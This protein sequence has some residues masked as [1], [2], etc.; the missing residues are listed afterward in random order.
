MDFFLLASFSSGR[1]SFN[2]GRNVA[3]KNDTELANDTV[4][5]EFSTDTLSQRFATD[6]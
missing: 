3:V 1:F 2:N 5:D 4:Q 6:E